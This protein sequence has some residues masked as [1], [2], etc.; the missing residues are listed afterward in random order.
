[1][2]KQS[3][4][5][6][7]LLLLF[8]PLLFISCWDFNRR[9]IEPEIREEAYVPVYGFDS[10]LR[11]V[12]NIPV[13]PTVKAGK[14]YVFGRYLFQVEENMGIHVIDYS[15]KTKPVKLT[16]IKSLGCS[17]LAV[18]NG[19]LITNNMNDLV[20]VNISDLQV[21]KEVSRNKF[22]FKNYYFDWYKGNKPPERQKYYVC[23]DYYKGDIISWKLEKKVAN[24]YCYN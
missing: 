22:A 23:P 2:R 7:H 17:E 10:S 20:S 14:I 8:T 19:L 9:P 11:A 24:A 4:N 12:K 16:F 13:Q 21:I 18:K 3:I 15:N 5:R 1:V 6:R